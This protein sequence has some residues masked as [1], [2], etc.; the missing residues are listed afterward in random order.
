M[1]GCC[2]ISVGGCEKHRDLFHISHASFTA[3]AQRS[4]ATVLSRRNRSARS[5]RVVWQSKLVLDPIF[6]HEGLRPSIELAP[7]VSTDDTYFETWR[8]DVPVGI[9]MFLRTSA[10]SLLYMRKTDE[11]ESGV[12][13]VQ[14]DESFSSEGCLV[15]RT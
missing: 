5:T 11:Y 13:K 15:E 14:Q 3:S 2:R 10:A 8:R 1:G 4:R 9:C 6:D 12:A 7:A